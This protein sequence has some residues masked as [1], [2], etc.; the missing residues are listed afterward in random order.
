M[1]GGEDGG[2]AANISREECLLASAIDFK[3]AQRLINAYAQVHDVYTAIFGEAGDV[4][5]SGAHPLAELCALVQGNQRGKAMCQNCLLDVGRQSMLLG[6]GYIHRCPVGLVVWGAPLVCCEQRQIGGIIAGQVVMW[7]V[8][9]LVEQEMAEIAELYQLDL[10]AVLKATENIASRKPGEIRAA[11]DLLFAVAMHIS[12]W[13]NTSLS[14][15]R[16]IYTQQARLAED[17]I[18]RKQTVHCSGMP[19]AAYPLEKEKELLGRVR[20]GDRTGAKEILNQILGD[21]LF[22]SAGKPEV[23]KA[24]LLELSVVLSRATVESGGRLQRLLGLN[25]TY[26]QELATLE[27]IEEICAW[28][29]KVLEVF[30]NEAYATRE[31]RNLP[32]VQRAVDHIKEH[33]REELTLEDVAQAVH[34]SP[35]YLSRLFRE[36]LGLTF[37]NYL[38]IVRMDE[39]KR[40][41][42]ET[43]WTISRIAA[44]VGYQDPSYFTKV[45]KKMEGQTPTQFRR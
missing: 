39:A 15:Q 1:G 3:E 6:E 28:I 22:N 16:D 7:P 9:E 8:D 41:L 44:L 35:Y 32:A 2:V 24:R 17:I 34:F 42:L 4:V 31:T 11:A 26:V 29:I 45:F 37:V 20:L 19:S 10:N 33:F 25:F 13:N 5:L 38:T 43:D 23:L 14:E 40:L 30:M 27:Q 21:I 36:E 12:T 18:E